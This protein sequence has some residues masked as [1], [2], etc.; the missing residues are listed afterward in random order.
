ME[1]GAFLWGILFTAAI[2]LLLIFFYY[3]PFVLWV[4]AKASGVNIS[5]LQLFL[6]RLRKVPPTVIVNAMIEAHKAGLKNITRDQLEAHYLAGGHVERVV[7]AL[8]SAEKA[9][10]DLTFQMATAIDLAGRDV[11]QAVQMSVNP[12]VIDTPPIAAV[13]KNGIQLIVKARI[14]VRANI[15][16][17]VGGAGEETVIA[18]VGEGI[19]SSIGAAE[20]HKEVL[21][22]P[23]SISKVVLKKGLDAGTAFEILSIDIADIDIGKNIGAELQMDQAQA[24]KNIAQAKAEERRAMAVALEQEMKAKAQE[25]RAHVIQ[26]EAEVPKAMADAFRSGNMGIMDY[27][28]MKNIQADTDMRETIA[29]PAKP[30]N[31]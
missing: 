23:D 19:I 13:A 25:A 2:I 20:T 11:F 15:K 12:K 30:N 10:I 26:A 27:Y 22:N 18:R 4:T 17:L 29:K 1:Q 21:E 14:T 6:M 24:D 8:V 9:N 3:V 16:Q 5:L 31:K 7:H 28:R